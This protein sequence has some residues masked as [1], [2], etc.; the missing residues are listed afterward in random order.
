MVSQKDTLY[1]TILAQDG[2]SGKSGSK[3]SRME[4]EAFS[5]RRDTYVNGKYPIFYLSSTIPIALRKQTCM[6]LEIVYRTFYYRKLVGI[7]IRSRMC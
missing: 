3:T 7:V 4:E 2:G 5:F 1:I 6:P